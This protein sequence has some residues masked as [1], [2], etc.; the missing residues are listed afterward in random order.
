[1]IADHILEQAMKRTQ[2][3]QEHHEHHH[4]KGRD[5]GKDRTQAGEIGARLLLPDLPQAGQYQ[6]S[7]R[8][9]GDHAQQLAQDAQSERDTCESCPAKTAP[10]RPERAAKERK[11]G[12]GR[13]QE[14]RRLRIKNLL[15]KGMSGAHSPQGLPVNPFVVPI[16]VKEEAKVVQAHAS[17]EE[18]QRQ[19]CCP[20]EYRLPTE[21]MD[22]CRLAC[23]RTIYQRTA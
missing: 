15:V 14:E 19:C 12:E 3:R 5:T 17:C 8:C 9:K 22:L 20:K 1:M 2:E 23:R 18:E 13:E 11:A 16:A 21:T 7:Y 6:Q 10:P 4:C